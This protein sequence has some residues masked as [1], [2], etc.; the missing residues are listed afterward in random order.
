MDDVD[1]YQS[2]LKRTIRDE[3]AKALEGKLPFSLSEDIGIQLIL[4]SKK[5]GKEITR[6]AQVE[7]F[8]EMIEMQKQMLESMLM[9]RVLYRLEQELLEQE[10]GLPLSDHEGL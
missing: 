7:N 4:T 8:K 3:I 9:L 6:S 1:L 2:E 5:G 10:R